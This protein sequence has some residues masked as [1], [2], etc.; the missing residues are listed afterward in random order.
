VVY[1]DAGTRLGHWR[2]VAL[3]VW[4]DR[5]TL[6]RIEGAHRV[7][8]ALL[9]RG[10]DEIVALSLIPDMRVTNF[11]MEDVV[12]RRHDELYKKVAGRAVANAVALETPG[13][14]AAFVR[15]TIAGTLLI[16]RSPVPTRIFESRAHAVAWLVERSHPKNP[17]IS[18]GAM[19]AKIRALTSDIHVR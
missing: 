16:T 3:F 15:A 14:T 4:L 18:S 9:A 17:E 19:T 6:P 13:F 8:D 7:I 2:N 11:T 5:I 12:R 1:R 10:G